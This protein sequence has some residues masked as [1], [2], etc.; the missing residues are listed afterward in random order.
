MGHEF[1]LFK[2]SFCVLQGEEAKVIII[3]LVRNHPRGRIGFLN[4]SNRINVL[5]SRAKHGMYVQ[6]SCLCEFCQPF[7][8]SPPPSF[9]F[10][11]PLVHLLM[12]LPFSISTLLR[13]LLGHAQ[14]LEQHPD[15]KMWPKVLEMLR[16]G[17]NLGPGL[18]L[19]C[20][21]H[22][23]TMNLVCTPADFDVMAEAGGCQLRCVVWR[24]RN[25]ERKKRKNWKEEESGEKEKRRKR[26]KSSSS[27]SNSSR[28]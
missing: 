27:S 28:K 19:K 21:N 7:A 24:F 15:S 13:Y 25:N 20:A 26:R 16:Q 1:F 14:S 4:I 12:L 9:S 5:L 17:G 22:P 23:G 18:P 10:L 8:I 11:L 6:L 2:S 3:S